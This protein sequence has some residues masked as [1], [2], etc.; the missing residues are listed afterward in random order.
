MYARLL[1]AAE[2]YMLIEDAIGTV[3]KYTNSKGG[4]ISCDINTEKNIINIFE[5]EGYNP[6]KFDK[7]RTYKM[8]YVSPSHRYPL[9]TIMSMCERMNYINY[10]SKSNAFI[11]ENDCDSEFVGSNERLPSIQAV[12]T[13]D[14]V[15]YISSVFKI[16]A[17]RVSGL[18]IWYC[19]NVCLIHIWRYMKAIGLLY[20]CSIR[21]R[22]QS[23]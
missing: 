9:G 13:D 11:I 16:A 15:I 19:P 20:Q 6:I 5:N 21:G 3:K 1:Y 17:G 14:N 12:D 10:A 7:S 8:L 4:N 22:L 18:L 23:I 2:H